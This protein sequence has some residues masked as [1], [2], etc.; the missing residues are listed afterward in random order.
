[1]FGTLVAIGVPFAF[2]AVT[3]PSTLG[4]VWIFAHFMDMAVYVTN[5]VTLIGF[6]IAIDYS[7]LVVF[8]LPGGARP[9][10]DAA[11]GAGDDDEDGRSGDP[12]LRGDRRD[13]PRAARLHAAAV[14]AARWAS[15]GC[16]CRCSRSPLRRPSCPRCSRSSGARSTASGSSRGAS[17]Q[18]APRDAR[19]SGRACRTRSCAARSPTWSAPAALMLALA[20]PALQL[21]LTSGDNRG[22]PLTTE[23]TKGLALLEET[24]GPGALAPQPDRDRHRR[25]GGATRPADGGGR[26]PA[27]RGAAA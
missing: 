18:P 12:V 21:H 22:V 4:A 20:I 1:M 7:M 9:H 10:Q 14:H 27:G 6:A 25:P 13:R 23:S 11:R 19:A 24:L 15:A 3:I 8:R 17:S 26:A 5:I 16:S 2:A